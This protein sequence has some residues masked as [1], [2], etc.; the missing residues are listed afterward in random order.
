MSLIN[1]IAVQKRGISSLVHFTRT[2]NLES[3]LKYGLHPR[4]NLDEGKIIGVFNDSIRVD[5]KRNANCLSI[6]FP[7][8][9]MFYKLRQEAEGVSWCV[10]TLNPQIMVDKKCAFYPSN[11]ACNTVRNVNVSQYLGQLAFDNM[12]SSKV[13]G[14]SIV[15]R[16]EQGSILD[17]DPT[18]VQAEVMVFDIIEPNYITGVYFNSNKTQLSFAEKYP[19][20]YSCSTE[21][22]WGVF[23]DR[24]VCRSKG[25]LVV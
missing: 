11:A 25:V 17:K 24:K 12:F 18:D 4:K 14:T 15:N 6:S 13:H 23:D 9:K 3:I 10:I 22:Y 8:S 20:I 19:N 16:S 7:N 21:G 2:E 5:E 1:N